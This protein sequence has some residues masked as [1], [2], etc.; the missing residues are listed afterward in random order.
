MSNDTTPPAD[1]QA[2]VHQD[3]QRQIKEERFRIV[4]LGLLTVFVIGYMTWIY[5]SIKQFDAE[6]VTRI[7]ALKIEGEIPDMKKQFR[8][9]ALD[10]AGEVTERLKQLLLDAP[11]ALRERLMAEAKAHAREGAEGL[12]KLLAA[13]LEK[14][15]R[16]QV[17]QLFV[18]SPTQMSQ[19][20]RLEFIVTQIR[21]NFV[22][23][24]NAQIAQ[25][26]GAFMLDLAKFRKQLE[27]YRTDPMLEPKDEIARDIIAITVIYVTKHHRLIEHD[28]GT[29]TW[30]EKQ[31]R[32][33]AQ[34]AAA[35]KEAAKSAAPS[36][37]QMKTAAME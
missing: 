33:A 27:N 36:Q 14:S 19:D 11:K 37:P 31:A 29:K 13:E 5:T 7:A 35:V 22:Q 25:H 9:F 3:Q 4:L 23:V 32:A 21:K 6:S 30:A 24:A 34:K 2:A 12:G 8:Q 16:D 28:D 20:E 10:Q 26:Q 17:D 1:F 15:F 18:K